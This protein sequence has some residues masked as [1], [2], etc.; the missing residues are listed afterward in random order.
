MSHKE[1]VNLQD[2]IWIMYLWT[3][4]QGQRW[5]PNSRLFFVVSQLH[6]WKLKV[7]SKWEFVY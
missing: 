7:Q 5:N 3:I 1:S 2:R 6:A 4:F